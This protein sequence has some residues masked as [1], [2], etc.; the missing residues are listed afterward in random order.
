MRVAVC[1]LNSRE[2]RAENLRVARDLLERA[3]AA[4]ADL[5]VLPEY[6][7]YLGPG[8]TAPAPAT[9]GD[10]K[11]IVVDRLRENEFTKDSDIK[12][13]VKQSVVV[14]GGEVPSSLAK[15]AAGEAL[16][17]FDDLKKSVGV[18]AED[19]EAIDTVENRRPDPDPAAAEGDVLGLHQ[20]ERPTWDRVLD[21]LG[22]VM[23]RT[24]W[25]E[26]HQRRHR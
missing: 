10:I 26:R 1:Q 22:N 19:P 18:R 11:S 17:Q 21:A 9:D 23:P 3:A 4:G 13:D 8:K 2:D 20:P 7:D 12:V 25:R 6:V 14:L 24:Q 16:N 15:R 5:A